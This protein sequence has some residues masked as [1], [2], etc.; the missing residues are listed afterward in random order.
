MKILQAKIDW[1]EGFANDARLQLLVDHVPFMDEMRYEQRGNLY[2][3]EKDGYVH[4]LCEDP[5]DHSGY[6]GRAFDLTM[7]DGT[8]VVL[9][10]PWS[11]RAAVMEAAGFTPCVEAILTDDSLAY[12]RGYT[13]VSGAVTLDLARLAL[14]LADH[15][16]GHFEDLERHGEIYHVIVPNSAAIRDKLLASGGGKTFDHL[17]RKATP[18]QSTERDKDV[19]S[20]AADALHELNADQSRIVLG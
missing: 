15:D 7:K 20:N 14:T 3:A 12:D 8:V 1:K 19:L 10:G 11:G 6:G 13:F 17:R 2:F 5:R 16:R 4:F 18:V 9:K